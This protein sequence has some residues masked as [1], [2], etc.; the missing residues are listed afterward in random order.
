[1]G[2][3]SPVAPKRNRSRRL[4]RTI[5]AELVAARKVAGYTQEGL[6]ERMGWD[7][8]VISKIER[9]VRSV[10]IAELIAIATH[11]GTKA[12]RIVERIESR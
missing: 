4:A 9:G 3:N 12:S 5:G 1:M 2:R 11:L 6:A 8:T 7:Q 10:S